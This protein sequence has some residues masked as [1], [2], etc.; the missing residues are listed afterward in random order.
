MLAHVDMR[1]AA[2]RRFR[3]LVDAYSAELGTDSEA[4]WSLVRQACALQLQAEW[5]QGAIVGGES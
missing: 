4:E 5:M 3:H 2:G 1:S